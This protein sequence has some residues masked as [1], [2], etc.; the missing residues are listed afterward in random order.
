M[1]DLAFKSF[2]KAHRTGR[3]FDPNG[4]LRI[5]R[6]R[7]TRWFDTQIPTW[8]DNLARQVAEGA[9]AA[10]TIDIEASPEALYAQVHLLE[11]ISLAD[12]HRWIALICGVTLPHFLDSSALEIRCF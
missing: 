11:P 9:P 6:Q 8:A 12:W 4:R 1:T 10:V 3:L 5:P 2:K 7:G